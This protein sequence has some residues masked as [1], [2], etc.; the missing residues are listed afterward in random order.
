M[1]TAG[2]WIVGFVAAFIVI[3]AKTEISSASNLVFYQPQLP[4]S[5]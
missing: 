1:K 2:K 4:K 3:I 5:E